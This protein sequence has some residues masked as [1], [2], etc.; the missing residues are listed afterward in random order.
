MAESRTRTL[1]LFNIAQ[2]EA[3]KILHMGDGFWA[4]HNDRKPWR[5]SQL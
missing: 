4:N 1:F 2:I 5:L 3:P